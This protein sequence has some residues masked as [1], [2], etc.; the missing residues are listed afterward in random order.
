[1]ETHDLDYDPKLDGHVE[2][3]IPNA[4]SP[5]ILPANYPRHN[6]WASQPPTSTIAPTSGLKSRYASSHCIE[7]HIP[8][9]PAA[10]R[11]ERLLRPTSNHSFRSVLFPSILSFPSSPAPLN[12]TASPPSFFTAPQ[13]IR[14]LFK[15]FPLVVHDAEP[16][17]ARAPGRVRRRARLHVFSTE[18]DALCG[19]ASYNPGCLK[20]QTYLRIA[21]LEFD[22]VP[23]TNHASPSGSLPYLL[24]ATSDSRP[25]IPLTGSRIAQYAQKHSLR[26][27]DSAEAA[28][29]RQE[30]YLSLLSQNIRPAWLYTLYVDP[31]HT[32]LLS[33]L[34]LPSSSVLRY[35]LLQTLR[36]AATAEILKTT[37]RAVIRPEQIYEDALGAFEALSAFLGD[38]TW[39]SGGPEPGL[40]DAEVF[41][42]T[43]LI[44][45]KESE[46]S[47]MVMDWEDD[48][49]ARCLEGC[50]NL[51]DHR[52][53]LYKRC[54]G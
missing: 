37:R 29:P 32:S 4:A 11:P 36:A 10:S 13:P 18:E 21:N 14:A 26:R 38:E 53:R 50:A 44:G 42:Y 2:A 23:S 3:R 15:F 24:P 19:R 46:T 51:V 41:A 33:K 49:L 22:L 30:A 39:F 43:F 25:E 54:W 12:M 8:R 34:Y 28:S 52:T 40:F 35:P 5:E 9:Q 47:E 6:T 27:I 7:I 1:M 31:I 48:A 16:L 45:R 17:P 20:W